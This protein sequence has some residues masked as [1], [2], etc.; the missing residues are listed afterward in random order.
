MSTRL[1]IPL[2]SGSG[3]TP[4]FPDRCINC[5]LPKHSEST[6]AVNRLVMRGKRQTQLSL[7]LQIPHCAQC[8]RST[9]VI[10][11]AALIP[12]AIGFLVVG[13]AS[14]LAAAYGV[15]WLGLDE[16]GRSDQ[17]P[18]LVLGA[19]L[20]LL[21]GILGGFLFEVLARLI[22]V[23]FYGMALRRAPLLTVQIFS[24]S[25]YVAGL[26]GSIA[27]DGSH[28]DLIFSND[29]I[30]SEFESLNREDVLREPLQHSM[31]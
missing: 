17:S 13:I 2:P 1:H 31:G 12:F 21:G 20:G 6:L 22:L 19:L 7:K 27:A 30:A 10:F 11:L 29:E 5:G 28:A 14:F 18:S 23:P 26:R 15:A 3:N 25:D 8:A 4:V 16:Y 24:D 9:Q